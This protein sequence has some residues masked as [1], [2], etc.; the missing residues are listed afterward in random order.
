MAEVYGTQ[1]RPGKRWGRRLLITFI[2][3]LIIV[4]GALVVG[5]RIAAAY[6]ERV[7]GNR[8]AQQVANQK[9]TSDKPTVEI[10]GV[11][12]LTQVLAGKYQEIKIGLPNFAGPAGNGKTIRLPLLDVRATDVQAPLN[13]IRNGGNIVAAAVTGV[14]TIDYAQLGTLIGQQGLK[15]SDKDGKLIGSAPVRALGQTFN[16]SGTAVLTVKSGVVQVRFAN[17][18]AAE[19]PNI[20]LVRS[21]INSYVQKLALDL[22]VPPLPLNLAVQKVQPEPD[23]LRFTAGASNV[24]LNSGGL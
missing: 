15:L 9:A 8:V 14:G 10:E 20:P 18:T 11:P 22:K 13:A 3:L 17:L 21:L 4:G 6:A 7:I 23:G 5:D 1:R 2:V 12:F 16:V 24:A 19:L